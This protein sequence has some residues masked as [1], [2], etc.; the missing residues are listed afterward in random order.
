MSLNVNGAK[1]H[2]NVFPPGM[3]LRKSPIN[4]AMPESSPLWLSVILIG[5]RVAL[6]HKAD[7]SGQLCGRQ[8]GGESRGARGGFQRG[9]PGALCRDADVW[10][11]VATAAEDPLALRPACILNSLAE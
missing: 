11:Q 3:L 2:Q 8:P 6:S 4:R 5:I 1:T 9:G 7:G 10:G